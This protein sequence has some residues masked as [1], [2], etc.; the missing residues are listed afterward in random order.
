MYSESCMLLPEIIDKCNSLQ[1]EAFEDK[2]ARRKGNESVRRWVVDNGTVSRNLR[3]D[4][5]EFISATKWLGSH[6]DS[7]TGG[8]PDL[9]TKEIG[10]RWILKYEDFWQSAQDT[11]K[12]SWSSLMYLDDCPLPGSNTLYIKMEFK[13]ILDSEPGSC[14]ENM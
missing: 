12:S 2:G 3:S 10:T 5:W 4:Q 9:Q 14:Q 8:F 7:E 1:A 13:G 6:N 11:D